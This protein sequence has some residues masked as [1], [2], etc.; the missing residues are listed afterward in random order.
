MAASKEVDV[1]G[2]TVANIA[3]DDSASKLTQYLKREAVRQK[4]AGGLAYE[5]AKSQIE[6]MMEAEA[7]DEIWESDSEIDPNVR[8]FQGRDLVGISIE[9]PE[10]EF[11]VVESSEEFEASLGHYIQFHCIAISDDKNLAIYKGAE[12][13]VSTG[14]ALFIAKVLRFQSLNKMPIRATIQQVENTKGVL[15][16]AKFTG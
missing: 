6:R 11:R 2:G 5:I 14:A 8:S 3:E 12:L 9:I 15:R 7:D 4:A 1:K 10:Q 16:L 13:L